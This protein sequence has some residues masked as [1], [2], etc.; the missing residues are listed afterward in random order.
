MVKPMERDEPSHPYCYSV[1]HETHIYEPSTRLQGPL[2]LNLN[3][4]LY[5]ARISA[6]SKILLV[7]HK[8]VETKK[9]SW[10][11]VY[12]FCLSLTYFQ[13]LIGQGINFTNTLTAKLMS[14]KTSAV[15]ADLH[16]QVG[17]QFKKILWLLMLIFILKYYS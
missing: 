10:F 15:P 12:F 9:N 13:V 1:T 4:F 16:P 6:A 8:S 17:V 3:F 14:S 2:S 7:F 11:L 5:H